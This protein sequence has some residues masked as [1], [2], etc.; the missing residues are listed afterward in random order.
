MDVRISWISNIDRFLS[1]GDC[2][3]NQSRSC[4][5]IPL[6]HSRGPD[7]PVSVS[8]DFLN[9][10]GEG[11]KIDYFFFQFQYFSVEKTAYGNWIEVVRNPWGVRE[12]EG[13]GKQRLIMKDPYKK[14]AL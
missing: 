13:K 5:E 2:V 6:P 10:Q 9:T 3:F 14:R 8:N 1:G 4:H 11:S 7:A 12:S